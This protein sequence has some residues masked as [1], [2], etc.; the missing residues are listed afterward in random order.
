[1]KWKSISIA[2][3]MQFLRNW[4]IFSLVST[5]ISI[6]YM[7]LL[8][9]SLF[10]QEMIILVSLFNGTSTFGGLSN[11]KVILLEEYKWYYSTDN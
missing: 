7:C 3:T 2:A 9:I 5:V 10:A 6:S 8:H 11:S 4:H 1:M